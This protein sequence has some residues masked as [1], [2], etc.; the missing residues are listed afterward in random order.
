MT[1]EAKQISEGRSPMHSSKGWSLG[2]LSLGVLDDV[3]GKRGNQLSGWFVCMALFTSLLL[4]CR[5]LSDGECCQHMARP[6]REVSLTE[7]SA[8]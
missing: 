4:A 8:L 1:S 7:T 3:F 2:V 5:D 6:L